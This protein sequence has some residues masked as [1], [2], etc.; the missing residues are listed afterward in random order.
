MRKGE[1]ALIFDHPKSIFNNSTCNLNVDLV[2]RRRRIIVRC[3]K[4]SSLSNKALS[5]S[6]LARRGTSSRAPRCVT[7]QEHVCA[8][9]FADACHARLPGGKK[10]RSRTG[11]KPC[12]SSR[13]HG[14]TQ[15]RRPSARLAIIIEL[16]KRAAIYR[17]FDDSLFVDIVRC[18]A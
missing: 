1:G 7:P 15:S 17:K 8:R 16:R 10:R 6:L 11:K 18:Q 2:R 3:G 12:V 4:K 13:S 5:L 14:E 9:V